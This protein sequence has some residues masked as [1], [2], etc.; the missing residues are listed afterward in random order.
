[1]Q[2]TIWPTMFIYI[3][4][5]I[6]IKISLWFSFIKIL[7]PTVKIQFYFFFFLLLSR[8]VVIGKTSQTKCPHF[9][10]RP[11]R[12]TK[13][14]FLNLRTS[15][16]GTSCKKGVFKIYFKVSNFGYAAWQT[17]MKTI[18]YFGRPTKLSRWNLGLLGLLG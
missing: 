2:H 11:I 3:S 6:L 8:S 4:V 16:P 13:L 7:S 1:M 15:H 14:I 10:N 12:W 5:Q 18:G 9:S 17:K